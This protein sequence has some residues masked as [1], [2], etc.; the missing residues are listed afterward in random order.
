[1][2]PVVSVNL[3]AE[4]IQRLRDS[5]LYPY[6]EPAGIVLLFLNVV[7]FLTG[8]A[9]NISVLRAIFGRS[10]MDRVANAFMV[11]LCVC[12]LLVISL[13]VPVNAGMEVY[14]SYVYGPALCKILAYVQAV[15]VC[16]S[17]FTLTA[18]SLDRYMVICNPLR[19]MSYSPNSRVKIVIPCIWVASMLIMLPLAIFSEVT[20]QTFEFEIHVV[21]CQEIWPGVEW[22]RAYDVTLFIVLFVLPFS[23]MALA[24]TKI[25][26]TLWHRA[27]ALYGK[28]DNYVRRN[29]DAIV[30]KIISRRRRAVKVFAALTVI[31]SFS[32]LPY[33]LL[34]LWFDFYEETK[35]ESALTA[36]TVHPFLLCLGLSDSAMNA[37]CYLALGKNC[38]GRKHS[39]RLSQLSGH[40]KSSR[41]L[42]SHTREEKLDFDY[43]HQEM[44]E[45]RAVQLDVSTAS[46]R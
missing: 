39:D 28:P 27:A 31:F 12:G 40:R 10:P 21:F 14:R 1:M 42:P 37:V 4:E 24:Y 25:G 22:K 29:N 34:I 3:S 9:A 2:A 41:T 35:R 16:T 43:E 26:Q 13:C 32:W 17:V 46:H 23:I 19:A 45:T 6:T 15:S 7:I 36:A 33:F 18:V 20:E 30:T 8:F 44:E 11:N 5:V 38:C